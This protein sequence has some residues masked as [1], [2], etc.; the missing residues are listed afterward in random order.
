ML[1]NNFPSDKL[2]SMLEDT[3]QIPDFMS[4]LGLFKEDVSSIVLNDI[5]KNMLPP[6]SIAFNLLMRY[7][8][9]VFALLVGIS[10][11]GESI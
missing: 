7:Q 5:K 3:E 1:L 2:S 6:L 10:A 11:L 9:I 8:N 4:H